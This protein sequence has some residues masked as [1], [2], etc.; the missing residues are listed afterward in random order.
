MKIGIDLHAVITFDE[1]FFSEF[2][3]AIV[4]SGGEIHVMT[5]SMIT[6]KVI[7]ELKNYGINYTHLFSIADYYKSKPDVVVWYD[8]QGRPWVSDELWNKAKGSY[9]QEQ[10]LD[11]VLDDTEEYGKHFTTSFAHCNIINK[12]GIERKPKAKMP[13]PP[14]AIDNFNKKIQ[15]DENI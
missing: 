12:S 9:A 8:E 15:I 3:H 6:D 7:D 4:K 13:P 14:E 10:G 5:G 11:L 2:S 1:K